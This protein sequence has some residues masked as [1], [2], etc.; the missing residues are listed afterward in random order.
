M[1][2]GGERQGKDEVRP[3]INKDAELEDKIDDEK[4]EG[5]AIASEETST[6]S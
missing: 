5:L 3:L 2:T 6:E 1:Q 4:D